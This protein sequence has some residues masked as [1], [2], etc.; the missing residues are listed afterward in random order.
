MT[1]FQRATIRVEK[2]KARLQAGAMVVSVL[3]AIAAYF[4]TRYVESKKA[5]YTLQLQQE[6]ARDDFLLKAAEIVMNSRTAAEAEGKARA[7]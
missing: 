2:L 6:H 4:T 3:L 1:A 5:E 7:M